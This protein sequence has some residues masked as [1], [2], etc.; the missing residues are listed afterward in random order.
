MIKDIFASFGIWLPRNSEQQSK[1]GDIISFENMDNDHKIALI[2]EN[3]IPFETLLYK[4]GHIMLYLGTF[5]DQ[6]MLLHNT[7]GIKTINDGKEGRKII[8]KT[9]ISTLNLG[10]KQ[11]DFDKSSSLL[12]NITSMNIVTTISR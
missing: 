9:I 4:K 1:I 2:K 8:G 7:W 3:A 5:D 11:P 6:V 10:E 12:D